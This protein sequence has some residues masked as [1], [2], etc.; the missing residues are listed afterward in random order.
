[1]GEFI[2]KIYHDDDDIP[3]IGRFGLSMLINYCRSE[4]LY[5]MNYFLMKPLKRR[6]S[7]D[8]PNGITKNGIDFIITNDKTI[9]QVVTFVNQFDNNSNHRLVRA[10]ITINIC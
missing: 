10:T 8:S 2:A 7:K 4:N 9:C 6:W 3:N 1:M 5:G